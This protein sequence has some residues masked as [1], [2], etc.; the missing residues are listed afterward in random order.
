MTATALE[1]AAQI[2]RREKSVSQVVE[3]H[4]SKIQSVN[5]DL[6][7]VVETRYD[8]AREEAK[9]KDETLRKLNDEEISKLP[10]F[11]GVPFTCKEMFA[12]A[13]MRCTMGSIHHRERVMNKNATVVDRMLSAG[14][15]LLGTTNVPEVGFWFEC[16]NVVYGEAKNPFDLKRTCGGS[17][18]GEGAIIG[19]GASPFGIGSDIGG[20]IRLPAA[21]CGIFGHK[22]SDRVVPL[23]GHYP[24]YQ[25]NASDIVGAKYPFTVVGPMARSAQD[26]EA[27]FRLMIGPDG[28]DQN[29]KKDFKL[30]KLLKNAE[31]LRVFFLPAPVMHGISDTETDL[32]RT[33]TNAARYLKEMGATVEEAEPRTFLRAFDFWTARAWSIEA[34]AFTSYL[35]NDNPLDYPRELMRLLTG[36]RQYTLPSLLMSYLDRHVSDRSELE[37]NL[38]DLQKLKNFL[39][40]KL[41][42]N[43]V[44]IMPAH[45]RKAPLLKSTFTRPFDFAYTG[46]INALGFPSTAVPMGLSPDGLPLSLQVIAA[47]DQ[48]HMCLSVAQM[49]ELGFGGYQAPPVRAKS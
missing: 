3:E 11:Y 27:L 47:E 34:K 39:T 41:G 16:D 13:E 40:G 36:R 48:D 1:I 29:I 32:S 4:I 7:A 17:S 15:I 9:A 21:F 8:Q 28:Y 23:T 35:A 10:P 30:Q 25:E 2:K 19:A 31:D 5:M 26:I 14:A 46:V 6:N 18:G 44:I 38:K 45:P 42:K 24:V 33:V 22:P 49:L 43:G 37:T 12:N 20:S